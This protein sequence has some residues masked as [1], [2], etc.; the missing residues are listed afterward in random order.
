[1]RKGILKYLEKFLDVTKSNLF[2]AKG[3][4]LVEGWA[5]ELL[6]DSLAKSIGLNLTQKKVSVINIGNTGLDRQEIKRAT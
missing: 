3:I 2:F 1:M 5:E 6:I 4:I